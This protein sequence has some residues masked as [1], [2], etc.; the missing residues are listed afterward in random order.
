MRN[1][2]LQGVGVFALTMLIAFLVAQYCARLVPDAG[3]AVLLLFGAL[4]ISGMLV[5][6]SLGHL[7]NLIHLAMQPQTKADMRMV[8][9][10]SARVRRAR[11]RVS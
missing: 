1:Q 2:L 6:A 8:D 9:E 4:F 3:P 5:S 10:I 7:L 11:V